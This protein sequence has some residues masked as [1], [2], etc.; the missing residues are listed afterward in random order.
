MGIFSRPAQIVILIFILLRIGFVNKL[1]ETAPIFK[2]IFKTFILSD[3]LM[4]LCFVWIIINVSLN[5]KKIINLDLKPL[6]FLGEISY[7]IYMYHLLVIFTVIVGLK[8]IL[9]SFS[10][11][12]STLLFYSII[13]VG[14]VITSSLSKRF[15]EDPFLRFKERFNN[16]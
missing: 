3:L 12:T 10:P 11:I 2:Q 15:F 5:P 9:N 13:T 7:G 16:T 14:I 6:N 4:M 8:S 1:I